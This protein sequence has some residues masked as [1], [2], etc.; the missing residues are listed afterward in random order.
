LDLIKFDTV[1]ENY[2]S[3]E[4]KYVV[5]TVSLRDLHK[6]QDELRKRDVFIAAYPND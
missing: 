3:D 1:L 5:G 6:I 2:I 4:Y